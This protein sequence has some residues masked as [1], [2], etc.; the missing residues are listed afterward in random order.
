MITIPKGIL[1]LKE[2]QDF[3]DLIKYK[4]IVARSQASDAQ[5]EEM[6]NEINEELGKW[7]QDNH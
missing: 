4:M 3:L 5:I 7:N 2:I 6:T 1:E